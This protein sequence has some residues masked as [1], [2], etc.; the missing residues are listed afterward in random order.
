MSK[1]IAIKDI[2][3][4]TKL[5]D[6]SKF[7]LPDRYKSTLMN[8]KW[9]SLLKHRYG[10]PEHTRVVKSTLSLC[11]VCNARIPAVVYEEGG[12][13]WLRKNVMNTAYLRTYTGAMP[14]CITTF[15]SGTGP[16]ILRRVWQIPIPI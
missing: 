12:A 2:S 10:L 4:T 16:N 9:Q 15:Y 3:K 11:P 5:V 13:I 14:R 7:N 1:Q 8:E 6:L